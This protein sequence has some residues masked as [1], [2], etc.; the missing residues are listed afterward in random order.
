MP[1]LAYDITGCY[2]QFDNDITSQSPRHAP[3]PYTGMFLQWV[4]TCMLTHSSVSD[5]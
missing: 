2:W 5:H 1:Y 3:P 4:Y